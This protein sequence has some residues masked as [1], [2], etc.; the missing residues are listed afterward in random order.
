MPPQVFFSAMY[1][2]Q[3]SYS[4]AD[5]IINAILKATAHSYPKLT[6]ILLKSTA[7]LFTTVAVQNQFVYQ[8]PE[9]TCEN[10]HRE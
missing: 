1:D 9:E 7:V 4:I 2:G 3:H 8:Q 5:I 6:M 10:V